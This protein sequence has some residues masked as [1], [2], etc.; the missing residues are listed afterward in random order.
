MDDTG[1]NSRQGQE[2]FLFF[3][4]YRVPLEPTQG[5]VFGVNV[6]AIPLFLLYDFVAWTAT[7]ARVCCVVL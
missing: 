4:V 7:I 2:I 3:G 6:G 5:G 1:F